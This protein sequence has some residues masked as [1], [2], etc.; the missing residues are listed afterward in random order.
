MIMTIKEKLQVWSLSLHKIVGWTG[1]IALLFWGI[2]GFMHPVMTYVGPAQTA[3]FPPSH[4][5]VLEGTQPIDDTLEAAG[6]TEASSVKIIAG[7]AANMLQ[8]TQASFEPRRYFDLETGAE[9]PGQ[10]I[11]QAVFLARYYSGLKEASVKSV[12]FQTDFD[13]TYP[14]VNR[15]LPVYKVTFDTPDSVTAFAYTETNAMAYLTN[16]TK[17]AISQFFSAI[18]TLDFAP[19]GAEPLRVLYATIMVGSL[20]IMALSGIGLLI[21]IRLNKRAPGIRGWHRVTSYGLALPL[22]MLSF[23]GLYHLFYS[24]GMPV[25]RNLTLSQPYVV[26]DA[27]FPVPNHWADLT[28]GLSV[29]SLSLVNAGNGDHLY[30]LGLKRKRG[31]PEPTTEDA[32][33]N[34]R[35]DGIPRTGPALYINAA[36][37]KTWPQ[38]DKELA[39]RLAETFTYTPREHITSSRLITHFGPEY[40]FRNK[41]L[42][43]W[44]IHYGEPLNTTYF[45]DTAGGVLADFRTDPGQLE[46][47]SFSFLHKWNFLRMLGRD[48]MNAIVMII[49][50][51]SLSLMAIIGLQMQ[52]RRTK[53]K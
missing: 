52:I 17:T 40:D 14:S 10:D 9:I 45:I 51:L 44:E 20:F 5:L 25:A 32:I 22:L 36:D 31:A 24:S 39:L 26:A 12:T 7:P 47:Y 34:A 8:V 43:V 35:F 2:S 1:G 49:L 13:D 18:H 19:E 50:V 16:D 3:F 27:T 4:P 15:L 53:N 46:A 29:N 48:V 37:G 6:I 41:R 30:R 21:F 23:S 11:D 28:A 38:G 42:P 33:R